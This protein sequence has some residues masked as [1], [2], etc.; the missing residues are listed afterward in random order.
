MWRYKRAETPR[1]IEAERRLFYVAFTRA[2]G[3]VV[4]VSTK[5]VPVSRFVGEMELSVS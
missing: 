5:G 3:R 2:Q 1:D 4:L